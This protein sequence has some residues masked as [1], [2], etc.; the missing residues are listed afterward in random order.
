L[1]I[2]YD[3]FNFDIQ[4]YLTVDGSL[5]AGSIGLEPILYA[6]KK[7]CITIMLR[8]NVKAVYADFKYRASQKIVILTCF[9][10]CMLLGEKYEKI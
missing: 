5:L 9:V 1:K 8:P 2:T 6:T 7:R 4:K 10:P 3:L